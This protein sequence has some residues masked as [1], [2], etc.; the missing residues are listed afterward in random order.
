MKI[1]DILKEGFVLSDLSALEKKDALKELSA[2]LESKKAIKNQT[3]LLQSLL[4]RESLGSTGI[5]EN[6]A[7]PHAKS[8]Q[9]KDIMAM[10][11]RSTDGVNFDSLDQKPVHYIC[12]LIAP[13]HSTGLHLKA[14]ARIAK[15]LKS[16]L[17]RQ[18]I[19]YAK[20]AEEI[21]SILTEED[22]KLD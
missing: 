4:D 19:L 2:F 16:S 8:D 17:L 14:L 6:V 22:N 9:V 20:S 21:Y 13:I 18:T 7:I 1:Q 15:L 11:A 5:G 10:F 12:L 3:D